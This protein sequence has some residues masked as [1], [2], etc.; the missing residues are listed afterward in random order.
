VGLRSGDY[1]RELEAP[2]CHCWPPP[3]DWG[4][5]VFADRSNG[6]QMHGNRVQKSR[7]R[8]ECQE[9]TSELCWHNME[10]EPSGQT[11]L[12]HIRPSPIYVS[13]FDKL[14]SHGV[15]RDQTSNFDRRSRWLSCGHTKEH[16][17]TCDM[18]R[19]WVRNFFL[20]LIQKDMNKTGHGDIWTSVHTRQTQTE[21]RVFVFVP[22]EVRWQFWL[23]RHTLRV[24]VCGKYECLCSMIS[25]NIVPALIFF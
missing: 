19:R 15:C 7:R 10:S 13:A 16:M 14:Q 8:Q 22:T 24:C 11:I 23:L 12:L 9:L 21:K 17:W 2:L 4:F 20:C 1:E 5:G 25:I 3:Q 18:K 6:K